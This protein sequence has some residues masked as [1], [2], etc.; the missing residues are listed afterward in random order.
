MDKLI[1]LFPYNTTQPSSPFLIQE[2]GAGKLEQLGPALLMLL[3]R[4]CILLWSLT[5]IMIAV[6]WMAK[7]ALAD[8][9][10]PPRYRVALATCIMLSVAF[11]L[12]DII[13]SLAAV[14]EGKLEL[15]TAFVNLIV[16]M[17]VMVILGS[18]V[19]Q[20]IETIWWITAKDKIN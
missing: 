15:S 19:M 4:P 10:G 8:Q 20:C 2:L 6:G 9:L 12:S 16:G 11:T 14:F 13:L 1:K 17:G 3:K 18:V 5:M 7:M